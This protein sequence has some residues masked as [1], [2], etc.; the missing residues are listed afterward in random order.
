MFP[1]PTP[2]PLAQP[3]V[4]S[5]QSVKADQAQRGQQHV[6]PIPQGGSW[7]QAESPPVGPQG[8]PRLTAIQQVKSVQTLGPGLDGLA[9]RRQEGC[10]RWLRKTSAPNSEAR[11]TFLEAVWKRAPESVSGR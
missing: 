7:G 11:A 8:I 6:F 9:V 5:P 1:S 10:Q 2:N 4:H 3:S